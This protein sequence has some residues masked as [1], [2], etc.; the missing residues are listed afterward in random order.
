M[1]KYSTVESFLF[2]NKQTKKTT[3]EGEKK[4]LPEISKISS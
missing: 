1:Q 3:K 4:K 2:K